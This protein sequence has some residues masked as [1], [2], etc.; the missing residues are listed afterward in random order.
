MTKYQRHNKATPWSL[1]AKSEEDE[2]LEKTFSSTLAGELE[3]TVRNLRIL[4]EPRA[5]HSIEGRAGSSRAITM[6]TDEVRDLREKQFL[7][8]SSLGR[9]AASKAVAEQ[10][11]KIAKDLNAR[12]DTIRTVAM[13]AMGIQ[14]T[15]I[16]FILERLFH[17]GSR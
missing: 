10:L 17:G 6:I 5:D 15:L 8:V 1:V 3:D 9:K 13:W 4:G 14:F 7:L 2:E 11:E 16:M 12:V